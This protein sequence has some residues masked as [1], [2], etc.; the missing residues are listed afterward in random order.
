MAQRISSFV[1]VDTT[2]P[3]R[4]RTRQIVKAHPEVKQ[5]M[6]R[7]PTTF[8]IGVACVSAQVLLAYLLR[9]QAWYWTLPVAYL[10][11]AFFSHTLFVVIHEAAHNLVFKKLWQNVAVGIIANFPSVVPTAIS[12]KNFHIKHHVFQGV[13]EL[14]ADLPD[15]YEARLIRNYSLGKAIW[16]F[17][18]PLFQVIRTVRCREVAAVDR[19]VVANFVAQVAFDVA[20][21][22]FFGWTAMLYLFLSFWFSV[23]LHPLGARW[24]QEHYLTLDPRQETYSYYG[25]LNGINLNVGFHNEHHDMPS[26]PWNNLPKLKA[27]APEFYE[28]LLHH[29]SYTKLFFRFLFDQEISLF[30][31]ITRKARGR[32]TLQDNSTPD[33]QLVK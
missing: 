22:Y 9:N 24:I 14:D 21:V 13:H 20:I 4:I 11:G 25:P 12:F 26:I 32:A 7:N 1:E 31:R 2:E 3:H 30:S 5:L 33:L 18:F 29:T 27:V 19:Y 15:W 28:P 6:T 10:V 16:L 8:L 23:G 17:F